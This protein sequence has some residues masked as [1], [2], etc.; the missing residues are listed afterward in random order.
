MISQDGLKEIL[1][2]MVLAIIPYMELIDAE[3]IPVRTQEPSEKFSDEYLAAVKLHNIVLGLYPQLGL[4]L[5]EDDVIFNHKDFMSDTALELIIYPLDSYDASK[6]IYVP[7]KPGPSWSWKAFGY[8]EFWFLWNEI[9]GIFL[10]SILLA[11]VFFELTDK[12]PE[13]GYVWLASI[14]FFVLYRIALGFF[15]PKIYFLRYG[16][17]PN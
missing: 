6:M 14:V 12:W 1:S 4:S 13:N 10:L 5:S 15:G 3:E 17:W 2:L 7:V 8:G 9:W 16:K 11:Y